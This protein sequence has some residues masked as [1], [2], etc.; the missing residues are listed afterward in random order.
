MNY[1]YIFDEKNI[2]NF[3]DTKQLKRLDN[4]YC[5]TFKLAEIDTGSSKNRQLI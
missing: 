2:Q 5:N 4:V 1:F 3:A